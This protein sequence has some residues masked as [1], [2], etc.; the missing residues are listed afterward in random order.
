[1]GT[2]RRVTLCVKC[3]IF[4]VPT[5]PHQNNLRDFSSHG[6]TTSHLLQVV[7]DQVPDSAGLARTN[8]DAVIVSVLVDHVLANSLAL[9]ASEL[10]EQLPLPRA[11]FFC[12][13]CC[14]LLLRCF[15]LGVFDLESIAA[16][17]QPRNNRHGF[18]RTGKYDDRIRCKTLDEGRAKT[19]D[20][21]H[22]H[23]PARQQGQLLIYTYTGIMHLLLCPW[24]RSNLAPEK[25][26]NFM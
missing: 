16:M 9:I 4:A 8:D 24:R 22:R 2:R 26:G 23:T 19:H 14:A 7:R 12:L 20:M 21:F 1:M 6:T 18:H 10:H 17:R 15:L 25:I 13:F 3:A 5:R 11:L